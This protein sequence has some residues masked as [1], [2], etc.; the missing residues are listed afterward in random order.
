VNCVTETVKTAQIVTNSGFMADHSQP[1]GTVTALLQAWAGGDVG[2][3]DEALPLVYAELRRC[4]A[5]YLRRERA[6][7]TLQPT[8]LVHEAYLRLVG[9]QRVAWRSRAHFFAV[10]AQMMRRILVDHARAQQAAKRPDATMRVP[11]DE[12]FGSAPVRNCELLELDAALNDLTRIDPRQGQIVEL[13]Y[14]GGLSE[15]E[16]AEVLSVSRSTVTRE[17]QT[18]RAWLFRQMTATTNRIG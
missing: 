8:A 5:G 17:W 2:A 7:H 18:A 3:R 4:A 12:H 1:V 9:Q 16:V 10:A 15:D 11:L 13:R 14:F 6:D